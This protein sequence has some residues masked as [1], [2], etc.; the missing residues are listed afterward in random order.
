MKITG[1]V[2]NSDSQTVELPVG[3][4]FPPHAST[5]TV[6]VV[7]VERVLCPAPKN[8]D[9]FFRTTGTE[10]FMPVRASQTQDDRETF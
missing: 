9:S 10:D 7:G 3:A 8:W 1:I 6:S 4:E 2:N 5:L